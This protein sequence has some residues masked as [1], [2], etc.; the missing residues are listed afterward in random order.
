MQKLKKI[1]IKDIKKFTTDKDIIRNA[2]KTNQPIFRL[3]NEKA[4]A[5][6]DELVDIE[7]TMRKCRRVGLFKS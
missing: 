3:C 7:I 6:T 5:N 1:E 2:K 4:T